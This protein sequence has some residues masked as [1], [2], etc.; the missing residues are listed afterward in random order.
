MVTLIVGR[1]AR[2]IVP[3]ARAAHEGAIAA[4]VLGTGL[5]FFLSSG[6]VMTDAALVL[7]TTMAQCGVWLALASDSPAQRRRQ[8]R[9]VS[10]GVANAH[11]GEA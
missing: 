5:L 1:K 2:E 9:G 7:G 11:R 10:G 8:A 3:G 4:G 6:A